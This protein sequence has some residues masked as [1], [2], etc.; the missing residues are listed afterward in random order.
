MHIYL[1]N[2]HPFVSLKLSQLPARSWRNVVHVRVGKTFGKR[3]R[4]VI[5]AAGKRE[6]EHVRPPKGR[7]PVNEIATQ[8][9]R[10]GKLQQPVYISCAV[11]ISKSVHIEH[12]SIQHIIIE[13][14]QSLKI[15]F[16]V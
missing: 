5:Y 12:S 9:R 4:R 8:A 7:V 6:R 3:V 13:T 14:K 10:C 2:Y 15:V 16:D 11:C 1:R